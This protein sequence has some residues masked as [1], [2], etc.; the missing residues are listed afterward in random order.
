MKTNWHI[1]QTSETLVPG[2]LKLWIAT[3]RGFMFNVRLSVPRVVYIN[4]RNQTGEERLFKRVKKS[5][6]R[7]RPSHYLYEWETEEE[8]F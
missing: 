6:P 5:L 1:L 8:L 2:V 4:S 3:E 7:G